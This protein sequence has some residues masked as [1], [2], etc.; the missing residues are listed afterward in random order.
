[1]LRFLQARFGVQ[2]PNVSAWR[3]QTVGDLTS[4]LRFTKP[5]AGSPSLPA[6][7][8]SFAPGCPTPTDLGP[9]FGP[10]V[11]INVP[12]AQKLPGQERGSARRR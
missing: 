8:N 4:T 3:R 9:F 7:S 11:P 2:A 6:T 5:N 1:M 12:T 10:G